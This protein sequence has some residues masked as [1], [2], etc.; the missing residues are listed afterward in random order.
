MPKPIRSASA[1]SARSSCWRRATLRRG[2]VRNGCGSVGGIHRPAA[3]C[4]LQQLFLFNEN[5]TDSWKNRYS[6]TL[7][8]DDITIQSLVN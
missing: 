8:L 4:P 6:G 7:F 1:A 3:D 2:D 5:V